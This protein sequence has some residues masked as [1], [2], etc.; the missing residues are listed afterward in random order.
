MDNLTVWE[1]VRVV[2]L[3]ILILGMGM[4]SQYLMWSH[5]LPKTPRSISKVV[6]N[7]NNAFDKECSKNTAD[8]PRDSGVSLHNIE[9]PNQQS[10]QS[11]TQNDE[12]SEPKLIISH[13]T[14][15]RGKGVY[16]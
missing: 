15:P 9:S 3:V 7:P 8:V 2:A 13:G 11:Y 12:N 16:Q 14:P 4:W 1:I 5:L 6:N 10:D